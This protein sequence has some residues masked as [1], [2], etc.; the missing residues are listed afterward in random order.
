E[1][2]QNK[3]TRKYNRNIFSVSKNKLYLCF[4][5]GIQSVKLYFLENGLESI[6]KKIDDIENTYS[7]EF[8]ENDRKF[9]IDSG[10]EDEE[11]LKLIIWDMYNAVETETIELDD[12]LTT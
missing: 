12:F 1:N 2:S 11:N 8:I 7:L 4:T 3:L 5:R 10:A 6:S 9:V